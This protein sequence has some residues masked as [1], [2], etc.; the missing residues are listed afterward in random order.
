MN[1]PDRNTL[2]ARLK[3]KK[4]IVAAVGAGVAVVA[5]LLAPDNVASVLEHA[6]RWFW[7]SV[8]G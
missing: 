8:G 3:G 2:R 5:T 4:R 1:V 6:F 7:G